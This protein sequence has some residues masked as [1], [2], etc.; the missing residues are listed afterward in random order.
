MN[1]ARVLVLG[2]HSIDKPEIKFGFEV[3]GIIHTS[4]TVTNAGAQPNGDPILTKP[5]RTG[6]IAT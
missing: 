3:K 2:G 6:V 5:I 4:R 1:D